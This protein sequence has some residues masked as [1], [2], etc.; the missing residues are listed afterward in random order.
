MDDSF[1]QVDSGLTVP[2]VSLVDRMQQDRE[3]LIL[4]WK[5]RIF[6]DPSIQRREDHDQNA[7]PEIDSFFAIILEGLANP[8]DY[9]GLRRQ[10]REGKISTLSPD[11]A[12]RF[13]VTLKTILIESAYEPI[14]THARFDELLIRIAQFTHERRYEEIRN[15]ETERTALNFHQ[16]RLQTLLEP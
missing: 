12:C 8:H 3:D 10:I 1:T 6:E 7:L 5:H 4:A 14:E 13:L 16:D 9:A 2:S 11:A 15:Q